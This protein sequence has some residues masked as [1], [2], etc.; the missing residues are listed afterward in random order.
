MTVILNR[1]KIVL[2]LFVTCFTLMM[3]AIT[4][5]SSTQLLTSQIEPIQVQNEVAN[6]TNDID[7]GFQLQQILLISGSV[8]FNDEKEN[9]GRTL[10]DIE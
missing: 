10:L 2:V 4:V 1:I 7:S 9:K 8:T 5:A 3:S 6:L